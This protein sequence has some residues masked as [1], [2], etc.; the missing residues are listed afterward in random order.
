MNKHKFPPV[1]AQ[2]LWN[3]HSSSWSNSWLFQKKKKRKT[4]LNNIFFVFHTFSTFA[5][6]L[7]LAGARSILVCVSMLQLWLPLVPSWLRLAL[8]RPK[9]SPSWLNL[10]ASCFNLG[11]FW[12]NLVP[13]L[14]NLV[15]HRPDLEPHW[16]KL[17]ASSPYLAPSWRNL[18]KMRLRL[19]PSRPD[20]GSPALPFNAALSNFENWRRFVARN[21]CFFQKPSH[22]FSKYHFNICLGTMTCTW[23]TCITLN[24]FA[25]SELWLEPKWPRTH[26]IHMI[27]SF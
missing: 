15:A 10:A 23:N 3:I 18:V 9:L 22:F 27:P 21:L 19:A 4:C 5:P 11:A 14:L 17:I 1:F 25:L 7:G 6:L 24:S 26:M 16:L 20:L 2:V 8:S 13:S 12:C